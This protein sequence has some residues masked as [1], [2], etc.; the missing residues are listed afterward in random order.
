M[1]K[2]L[3]LVLAVMMMATVAFANVSVDPGFSDVSSGAKTYVPGSS[4]EIN[5]SGINKENSL[6]AGTILKSINS[7]NYSIAK[8]E[9][10]EGRNLVESVKFDDVNDKLV[11][12]LKQNYELTT[13]KSLYGEVNLKGKKVGKGDRPT[14]L[15]IKIGYTWNGTEWV[16]D[17][18][19]VGYILA[20]GK[21]TNPV[22]QIDGNNEAKLDAKDTGI[23][24]FDDR[25]VKDGPKTGDAKNYLWKVVEGGGEKQGVLEFTAADGDTD[26]EVRVYDG[27]KLY[28]Y[29]DVAADTNILKKY[30]DA[31]ADITFLNFPGS[32]TFDATATVRF[33][34]EEGTYIYQNVEG[35]LTPITA[36]NAGAAGQ[37]AGNVKWDEDEGAY[38]LKTR[39][40]GKY[41]F[42]DKPL[43]VTATTDTPETN[44]PDTGAN[45]VVGVATALAAVAL[46]SAAAVSLKK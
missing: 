29:N 8:I 22:I 27:N 3:A 43:K 41:V 12:K 36:R 19:S 13:A 31:D 18:V 10:K 26:I 5:D 35:N 45:D 33:Y 28:L 30:A 38:V 37:T 20:D 46:V 39:T 4:I 1:K 40:L 23:E 34:K 17:P 7:T 24:G 9:W 42:S 14:D 16:K 11:V 25:G 6:P 32:P 21:G 44:N 15:T 2:V